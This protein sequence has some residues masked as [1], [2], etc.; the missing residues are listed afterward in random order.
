MNKKGEA[1]QLLIG[2]A[3][4]VAALAVIMVI[5]FLVLASG[6]SQIN[7]IEGNTNNSLGYNATVSMTTSVSDG[8]PP[9]LP[10]II[11][12]GVGV[13]LI[14]LVSLFKAHGS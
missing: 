12:A 9:F 6:K 8:I 4:S 3:T 5:T 10:I 1:F 14:G 11:L 7:A 13:V 2:L